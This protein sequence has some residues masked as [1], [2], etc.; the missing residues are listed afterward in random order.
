MDALIKALQVILALSILIIIHEAG[1]FTFARLF[2]I[3]VEKFYLFFDIGGKALL[4][5][6]R[7]ETE[8]GIGW[9]P[10]GG[11]CKI[12]GM[13]DESMDTEALKREPQPWEFRTRPAWQRLL[14]MVG[15]V[16]YN[17]LFAI[18]L[19]IT[20]M[21]IWGQSYI[22]NEGAQIYVDDL[23]YE[24]G[25]RNGDRIL[26]FDDYVP[27]NFG[28]LQADLARRKVREAVLLRG[29][30]TVR[31]YIDHAMIGQVLN[32]P[33]MF[34]LAIPFVVDSV[35]AEGP[36]AAGAL[37]RGDRIVSLDGQP[38]S[39]VQDALPLLA[40]H[41]GEG[42]SADIEREGQLLTVGLNVSDQGQIGVYMPAVNIQR[43]SYNVLTAIP[44]GFR[45]AVSTVGGY[46]QDLRLLATPSSGAYKSVGSFIAI[47]QVFPSTWDWYRFLSIMALLSI[48]LAVMNL[49]PI[50]GLDGGHILF[51]LVEII[52]G[53]KPSDRFLTIAQMVGMVLLL[54]LMVLAFGNDIGRL[55]H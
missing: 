24:M 48:M 11:Y 26:R 13:V 43:R 45:Y 29:T 22:S 4:K 39:F 31:L 30:D 41:A 7:G 1:H 34:D 36:N 9:L 47:G 10:L 2:K 14:V 53:R 16:L 15:G 23:A 19:Y 52:T 33:M 54:A 38:V 27:E 17:F 40:A 28:M 20:I 25:F 50:P 35:A 18:L 32:T 5:F 21:G 8:Y 55:I 3:R 44:A 42:I 51:V 37:R 46:L 6:R 12:A 49:L